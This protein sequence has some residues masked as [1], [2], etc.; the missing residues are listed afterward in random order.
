MPQRFQRRENVEVQRCLWSCRSAKC[1]WE[2]RAKIQ[3]NAENVTPRSSPSFCAQSGVKE[4][5][6][7]DEF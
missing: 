6:R 4:R 3:E 7:G 2:R 1:V 5:G